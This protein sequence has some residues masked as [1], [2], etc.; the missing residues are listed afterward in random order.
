MKTKIKY[1]QKIFYILLIIGIAVLGGYAAS[2]AKTNLFA[3]QGYTDYM[4]VKSVS[5]DS[6]TTTEGSFAITKETK[7]YTDHGVDLK[8]SDI[9]ESSMVRIAFKR[10]GGRLIALDIVLRTSKTNQ[11]PE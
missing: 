7:I 9:K 6:L 10:M 2:Y 1:C 8:Y 5:E 4:T 3:S 11:Y